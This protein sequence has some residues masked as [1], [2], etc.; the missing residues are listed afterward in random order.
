MLFGISLSLFHVSIEP[1][2]RSLNKRNHLLRSFVHTVTTTCCCTFQGEIPLTTTTTKAIFIMLGKLSQ[3][4]EDVAFKITLFRHLNNQQIGIM[5]LKMIN[6]SIFHHCFSASVGVCGDVSFYFP[7]L[8][9]FCPAWGYLRVLSVQSAPGSFV[10]RCGKR[11]DNTDVFSDASSERCLLVGWALQFLFSTV[12]FLYVAYKPLFQN[13][14][15]WIFICMC[16]SHDVT[17]PGKNASLHS[18]GETLSYCNYT[19]FRLQEKVSLF[20]GNS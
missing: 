9:I 11:L 2:Q 19:W 15:F 3:L 13:V 17:S 6:L 12:E 8:T 18:P 14:Y 10:A 1:Q 4:A 16:A 7:Y 5:K 20:I